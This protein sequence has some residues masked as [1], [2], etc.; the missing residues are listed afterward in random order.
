MYVIKTLRGSEKLSV[1]FWAYC[2]LGTLAIVAA[3][4]FWSEELMRLP[5]WFL[6]TLTAL[7]SAYLLWAHLSLWQCAF[8]VQR[9]F[10]GYAARAY[11]LVLVATYV[12]QALQ[13]QQPARVERVVGYAQPGVAAEGLAFG[14]TSLVALRATRLG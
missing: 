5:Q 9:R 12:F 8:N 13:P 7:Y 6:Y 3:L 14:E 4:L 11:V 2:V 10:W 1:V